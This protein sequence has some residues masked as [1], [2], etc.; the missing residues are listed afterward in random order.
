MAGQA[1]TT[2]AIADILLRTGW[3][4]VFRCIPNSPHIG[5]VPIPIQ[6]GSAKQRYPDILSFRDH[7]LRLTEVEIA[8]TDNIADKII[9]RFDEQR[10]ALLSPVTWVAWTARVRS[11]TGHLLPADCQLSCELVV[12]K[13]IG[14][15][16]VHCIP[17]LSRRGIAVHLPS[18]YIP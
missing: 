3:T 4:V 8:L 1:S 14:T 18:T 13:P 6:R 10:A 17:R 16:H 15:R 7:I 5:V 11:L 9:E 2:I 12:C